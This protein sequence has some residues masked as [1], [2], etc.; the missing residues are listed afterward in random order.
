MG[1]KS[2]AKKRLRQISDNR[3]KFKKEREQFDKKQYTYIA[4]GLVVLVLFLFLFND[5][6]FMN[7]P[8]NIKYFTYPVAFTFLGFGIRNIFKQTSSQEW[9]KTECLIESKDVNI[10]F[11]YRG[12]SSYH[13]LVYYSYRVGGKKFISYNIQIGM[14]GFKKYKRADE[15][16]SLFKE[17]QNYTCYY[18]PKNPKES[19]LRRDYK[20]NQPVLLFAYGAL[21]FFLP[22]IIDLLKP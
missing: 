7:Q 18:N 20:F 3:E 16:M 14:S 21:F 8:F 1:K 15:A 4:L 19:M 10:I 12:G 11:N 6:D 13:P 2:S 22:S 17:G 5:A 9:E